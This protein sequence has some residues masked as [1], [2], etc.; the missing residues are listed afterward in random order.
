V[1]HVARIG[2]RRPAYRILVGR[3]GG[4]RPIARSGVD[5]RIILKSVFKKWNGG[6]HWIDVALDRNRWQA[7]VNAVITFELRKMREI[8]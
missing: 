5:G 3:P 2:N 1:G 6:M 4:K 7:R 8:S